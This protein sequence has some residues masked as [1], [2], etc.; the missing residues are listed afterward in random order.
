MRTAV[1]CHSHVLSHGIS[2]PGHLNGRCVYYC[3]KKSTELEGTKIKR[4]GG[5]ISIDHT[6]NTCRRSI[7]KS[8]V[9]YIVL[10]SEIL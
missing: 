8:S 10:F 2:R 6:H 7:S 9:H 3:Q 4:I 1:C 5:K